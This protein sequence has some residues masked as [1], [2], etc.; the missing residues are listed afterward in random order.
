MRR[1]VLLT[2]L[3]L[4]GG[5]CS[6][7]KESVHAPDAETDSPRTSEIERAQQE[8]ARLDAELEALLAPGAAATPDCPRACQLRA[9]ICELTRRICTIAERDLADP[10]LAL[11]C[12]DAEERCA[13]AREMVRARCRDCASPDP[14]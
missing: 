6:A 11:A 3:A 2:I 1:A 9:Q 13:R 7:G 4:L 12:R 5:A 10:E 14:G 8:L